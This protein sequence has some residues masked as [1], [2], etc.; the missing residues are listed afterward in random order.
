MDAAT[1]HPVPDRVKL[2]FAIF[3]ILA[4]LTLSPYT[5]GNTGHQRVKRHL[6]MLGLFGG[7]SPGV[8]QQLDRAFCRLRL[9]MSLFFLPSSDVWRTH[10]LFTCHHAR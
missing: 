5:H 10:F 2:S 1:K 7:I 3:Y 8:S 4:L 6:S 9:S